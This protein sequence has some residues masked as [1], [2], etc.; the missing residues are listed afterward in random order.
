MFIPSK[1]NFVASFLCCSKPGLFL[2]K[3]HNQE[4]RQE[5]E[6]LPFRLNNSPFSRRVARTCPI[7][8]CKNN[9]LKHSRLMGRQLALKN[10]CIQDELKSEK[11]FSEDQAQRD[12][13]KSNSRYSAFAQKLRT[14]RRADSQSAAIFFG[15]FNPGLPPNPESVRGGVAP[16]LQIFHSAGVFSFAALPAVQKRSFR[17]FC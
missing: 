2:V 4:F 17:K 6:L 12:C 13:R 1:N 10:T 15:A 3:I 7:T 9:C 16:G 8:T 5:S 14:D 11:M